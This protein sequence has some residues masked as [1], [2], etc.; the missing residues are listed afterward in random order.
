M[1]KGAEYLIVR[2]GGARTAGAQQACTSHPQLHMNGPAVYAFTLQ[3][4][5]TA[6]DQLL[7]KVGLPKESIDH[8]LLH[9]ANGFMLEQLRRKLDVGEEKMPID[10]EDLGN[11]VSATIP[12]LIR[13]CEEHSRFRRGDKCVLAGFG[14]GFS[15][16]IT[17]LEWLADRSSESV[18]QR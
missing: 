12:I 14:V 3:A 15:W 4:V 7:A 11:T 18:V 17:Y 2:E 16:A 13:R 9:Q 6:V 10:I 5:A 1:A 8:F